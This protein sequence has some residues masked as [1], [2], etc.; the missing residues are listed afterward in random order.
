MPYSND[1]TQKN[2]KITMSI[3]DMEEVTGIY[4]ELHPILLAAAKSSST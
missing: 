1:S 4:D 3:K 2:S